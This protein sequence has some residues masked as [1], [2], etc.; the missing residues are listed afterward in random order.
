LFP[1]LDHYSHYVD[2]FVE[3]YEI[4]IR[5]TWNWYYTLVMSLSFA[6]CLEKAEERG[7]RKI[8]IIKSRQK[9]CNRTNIGENWRSETGND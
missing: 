8:F 7:I 4:V 9:V 3:F 6:V 1:V 5:T 2:E